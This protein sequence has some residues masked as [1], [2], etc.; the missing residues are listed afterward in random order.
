MRMHGSKFA[1]TSVHHLCKCFHTAGIIPRQTSGDIVGAFHEQRSQQI[2]PLISVARFYVQLHWFSHRIDLLDRNGLIQKTALGY[3]QTRQQLLRAR[4]GAG[5]VRVFFVQGLT[6]I[7]VHHNH[8][9]RAGLWDPVR[10]VL[11]GRWR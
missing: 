9:S 2:D 4:R 5:L 1:R 3:D 6:R 11:D 10:C 8:R 7:R